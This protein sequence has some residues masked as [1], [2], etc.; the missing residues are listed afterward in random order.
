MKTEKL[1]LKFIEGYDI[2]NN[3]LIKIPAQAIHFKPAPDKWSINEIIVHLAD[4]EANGFIRA[5]KIIAES[6]AKSTVSEHQTWAAVLHYDQMNLKDA[7]EMIKVLRINLHALLKLI[8]EEIWYNYI[9]HPDFGKITLKDW[10]LH[11]I[12]HIEIHLQQIQSNYQS[13]KKINTKGINIT[14]N[15]KSWTQRNLQ[16]LLLF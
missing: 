12:N 13:W 6:G 4:C 9:F 3:K 5:K 10:I 1:L 14:K 15:I 8:D 16:R 11:Y 7:L 2:L